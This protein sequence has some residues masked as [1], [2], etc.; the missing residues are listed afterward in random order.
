MNLS[1]RNSM[2]P[3]TGNFAF[4]PARGALDGFKN[5]VS[6]WRDL[7]PEVD[8]GYGHGLH[9]RGLFAGLGGSD[10]RQRTVHAIRD[11]L[12]ENFRPHIDGVAGFV[13]H[14]LGGF[15]GRSPKHFDCFL[16]IHAAL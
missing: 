16:F 3:L 9:L 14:G 2:H 6:L 11:G 4:V 13:S 15:D 7:A 1:D 12:R 10:P 8:E 5:S